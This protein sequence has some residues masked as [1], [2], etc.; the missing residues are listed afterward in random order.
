MYSVNTMQTY[1]G[2]YL[3][4]HRFSLQAAVYQHELIKLEITWGTAPRL[5]T[6]MDK[7]EKQIRKTNI[8]S[9]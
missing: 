3:P 2:Q 6:P 4:V 9:A 1:G 5:P 7:R 8:G